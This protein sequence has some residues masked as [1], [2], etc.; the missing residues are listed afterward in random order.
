MLFAV[1]YPADG[2]CSR[3]IALMGSPSEFAE[4]I[5]ASH[6]YLPTLHV[7]AGTRVR[8]IFNLRNGITS[9]RSA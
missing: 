7:D 2:L 4:R 6:P 1:T 9:L 3:G 8:A 5:Y